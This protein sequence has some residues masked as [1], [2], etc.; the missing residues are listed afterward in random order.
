MESTLKTVALVM[1]DCGCRRLLP[2]LLV[3]SQNLMVSET[4]LLKASHTL[5]IGQ[6]GIKLV[7]TFQVL[8][9]W[10]TFMVLEGVLLA[11]WRGGEE[12]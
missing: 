3:A 7:L 4:L 2:L 1:K 11:V 6:G 8:P 9:C 10:L 5:I 12:S